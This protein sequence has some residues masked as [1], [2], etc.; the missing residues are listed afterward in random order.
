MKE[1]KASLLSTSHQATSLHFIMVLPW[2]EIIASCM[3]NLKEKF[4]CSSC[5]SKFNQNEQASLFTIITSL[6]Y[7]FVLHLPKVTFATKLFFCSKV[8]LDV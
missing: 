7:K 4:E 1:S 8:T 2:Y 3:A 6:K 5:G